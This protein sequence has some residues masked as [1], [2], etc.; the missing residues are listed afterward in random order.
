MVDT[1]HYADREQHRQHTSSSF[2]LLVMPSTDCL[3]EREGPSAMC[4]QEM[5]A[6][7]QTLGSADLDHSRDAPLTA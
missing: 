1:C 6:D 5:W 7:R 2:S 4:L 3:R